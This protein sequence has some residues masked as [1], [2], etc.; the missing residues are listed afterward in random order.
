M[1]KRIIQIA[2]DLINF[3]FPLSLIIAGFIAALGFTGWLMY[4][5]GTI[6]EVAG[7]WM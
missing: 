5:A 3:W 6:A 4:D 2:N 1:V 7:T